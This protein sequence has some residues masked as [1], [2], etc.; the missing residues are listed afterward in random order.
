[1]TRILNVKE[2]EKYN[3]KMIK[4]FQSSLNL[5]QKKHSAIDLF[6]PWSMAAIIDTSHRLGYNSMVRLLTRAFQ[7]KVLLLFWK[8]EKA[9]VSDTRISTRSCY[10]FYKM[11][12]IMF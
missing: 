8:N 4:G 5:R 2:P 1:M 12:N 9:Q 7:I 6:Y 11:C 10:L 3:L